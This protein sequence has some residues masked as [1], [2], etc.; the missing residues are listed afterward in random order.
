MERTWF[1]R[2]VQ[3]DPPGVR[4]LEHDPEIHRVTHGHPLGDAWRAG[5]SRAAHVRRFEH[6]VSDRLRAAELMLID[7][8]YDFRTDAGGKDPDAH[9]P[10]LRRYHQMLWSKPLPSGAPFDLDVTT[11]GFYLHHRSTLGE[12]GLSSDAVIPSYDRY[13]RMAPILAQIGDDET[14]AFNTIGYTIGAM[15]VFPGYRVDGRPTLN[16]ARGFHP[17]IRDRMDLTLECIRRHYRSK[18]SPLSA[19][20][21]RYSD[22][23]ALFSN[24]RGYV[25][26][27]LLQDMVTTNAAAVR[28]FMPFNDFHPPAM[29]TDADTYR[30]Y[31]RLSIA[32]IM[33]RNQ[34]IDH[35]INGR[36]RTGPTTD[37]NRHTRVAD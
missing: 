5:R 18:Q 1:A 8:T 24:F 30:E 7:T 19:T 22:F 34:R 10:T 27:F 23:F 21:D 17:R 15:M 2:T 12:F 26:F 37:A 35:L 25:D 16:G 33:A 6:M 11:P 14:G 13:M 31:R 36:N 4:P 9:S 32:F 3:Y 20:L 28:F 29:P